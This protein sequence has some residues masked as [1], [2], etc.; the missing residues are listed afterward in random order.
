MTRN[1]ASLPFIASLALALACPAQAQQSVQ[2]RPS[3]NAA[4][5][6]PA[7]GCTALA[8]LRILLRD[9]KDDVAAA[10]AAA[11]DPKSD[12]GCGIIDRSAVTGIADHV[13]LNGR[14]YDCVSLQTT[15][16]CHWTLAGSV[17]P[18]KPPA[19]PPRGTATGS[20]APK[21]RQR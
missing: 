14:A 5:P 7:L 9:A 8:N 13:A 17:T 10:I 12:L 2:L 11:T 15:T 21:G 16:L 1:Q 4:A 20:T 3:T 19:E 18:A 6:P